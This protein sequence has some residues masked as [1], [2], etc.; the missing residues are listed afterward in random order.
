MSETWL[1]RFDSLYRLSI[2][3]GFGIVNRSAENWLKD[4]VSRV[5]ANIVKRM[6]F[7]DAILLAE[8]EVHN[9][10]AIITWNTKDFVRRSRI[11]VFSPKSF[12][13]QYGQ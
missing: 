11:S 3:S 6:S 2:I 10:E 13:E 5:T 4:F 12:L 8:A 7:G 1:R 9:A